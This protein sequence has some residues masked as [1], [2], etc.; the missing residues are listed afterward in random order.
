MSLHLLRSATLP[1]E[2]RQIQEAMLSRLELAPESYLAEYRKRF[3]HLLNADDAA[4]LFT[5]YCESLE[6][7][8][9][10]RVAVHPAAQWIRDELLRRTL[11]E[12][13]LLGGNKIVL[14]AGGTGSGKSTA[15]NYARHVLSWAQAVYDST[16]SHTGHAQGLIDDVLAAGKYVTVIYVFRP[17]EIAF[18]NVLERARKQGRTVAISSHIKSHQ[19]AAEMARTLAKHYHQDDRVSFQFVDNSGTLDEIRESDSTLARP[20]K[21]A[22]VKERLHAILDDA[23]RTGRISDAVYRASAGRNP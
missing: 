2:E 22:G 3:G 15:A 11:A 16:L 7:R 12:P 5:E 17:V 1:E 20:R 23:H 18:L 9:R 14:T 8:A 6:S 10:L 19:G 13:D 4:E 21:Y